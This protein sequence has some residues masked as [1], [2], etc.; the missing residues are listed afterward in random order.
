MSGAV[1][2]GCLTLSEICLKQGGCSA[3]RRNLSIGEVSNP[4]YLYDLVDWI[5]PLPQQIVDDRLDVRPLLFGRETG[6]AKHD[7]P[8][9]E[10]AVLGQL[11]EVIRSRYL[12]SYKPAEFK[13]DGQYRPIEISARKSGRKLRIYARKGYVAQAGAST[14]H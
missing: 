9:V 4:K 1:P 13:R 12:I 5:N 2:R 14:D 10:Q 8:C 7:K 11:Q 3:R 6:H